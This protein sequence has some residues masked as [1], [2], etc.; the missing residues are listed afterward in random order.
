MY[1]EGT[2]QSGANFFVT[3]HTDDTPNVAPGAFIPSN[4]Y[5]AGSTSHDE[6]VKKQRALAQKM[7]K[8][9]QKRTAAQARKSSRPK[10]VLAPAALLV[11]SVLVFGVSVGSAAHSV[12]RGESTMAAPIVVLQQEKTDPFEPLEYGVNLGMSEPDFFSEIKETFVAGSLTFIEADLTTM[13]IRFYKNGEVAFEAPILS[14]G[15]EGSWWE[16]PAG[17]YKVEEKKKT[18]F[19]SFGH[20]YQPYNMIFQGNFFIHGW[21]YYEGGA[22]VPEGFSGG[23]VRLST[24]D[25]E[26]LYSLASVDTPVLVYE[27]SFSGDEFLYEP[28]VPELDTP[29]YLVADI[30]NNTVLA[31][32]DLDERAPIASVTK[33][34]TALIAAEYINLD[35]RVSTKQESFVQSLIPRL[36]GRNTV[37]MYSLL[38]LLL[39]ESSNESAEVIAA[40]VGR[41]KF[42]GL[43]NKKAASLGL[44][45][46]TFVDPSGLGAGNVSSIKDLLRLTQYIYHNR[47]FIFDLTANQ[48]LPTAYRSGEFGE[49]TNFNKVVGIENLVGGKVGE[50]AAAGQTSVSLHTVTV[51]GEERI[52]AIVLLGSTSRTKDVKE[53]MEYVLQRFADRD[54][55]TDA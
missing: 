13:E 49:L 42:I 26:R 5:R 22:P 23:C 21:P 20:V 9:V 6:V 3:S 1:N 16:T 41:E 4:R 43:M 35:N 52:V 29:Q 40:Q 55:S 24:E 19:S 45:N 8:K 15:R 44:T 32:S 7:A 36:S 38:Q 30:E 28:R 53:L 34:M 31:S 12:V 17:L 11:V 37:S 39:V 25:A 47:K 2:D 33:L 50:T 18:H 48:D 46:T 27:E 14:K 54:N 51:N 10:G